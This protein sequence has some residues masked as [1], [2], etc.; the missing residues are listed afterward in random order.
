ML[1]GVCLMYWMMCWL[2]LMLE[3]VVYYEYCM[4]IIVEIV[5]VDVSF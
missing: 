4:K 3:G 1:F 2:L 5:E